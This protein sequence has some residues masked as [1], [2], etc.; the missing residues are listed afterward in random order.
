MIGY[1][2]NVVVVYLSHCLWRCTLWPLNDISYSK[3]LNKWI[4]S[5][6]L[7]Y[8]FTCQPLHRSWALKLPTQTFPRLE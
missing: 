2:H 8:D 6:L 3:C 7:G 5:A 1:W 4:G